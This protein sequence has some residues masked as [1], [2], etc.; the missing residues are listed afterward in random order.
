[1]RIVAPENVDVRGPLDSSI[2]VVRVRYAPKRWSSLAGRHGVLENLR[3][4]PWRAVLVPSFLFALR[5]AVEH[6]IDRFR[7]DLLAAHFLVPSGWAAIRAASRATV[8]PR[9]WLLGHGTDVDMLCAAPIAVRRA[10]RTRLLSADRVSLPSEAKRRRLVQALGL[11]ETPSHFEVER[12]AHAV[13]VPRPL[14]ANHEVSGDAPYALF[15]GRLIA[16]KGVGDLIRAAADAGV[17]LVVAGDGPR[18]AALRRT[19]RRVG[20]DVRFTGW[21]EGEAKARL[22]REAAVVCVPS[23]PVGWRG[24]GAPLV[25]AE[26]HAYGRPVIASRLGGMVEL[27]DDVGVNATLIAVGDRGGWVAALRDAVRSQPATELSASA[28]SSGDSSRSAGA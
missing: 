26:A 20:A 12:M 25:L 16:Q 4:A 6:E 24:E 15:L 9:V 3:E 7:P 17:S 23:R 1:V 8:A 28:V 14:R 11:A 27:I 13:V 10:A 19:A 2:E 22:L 5:R 18:L 21:V